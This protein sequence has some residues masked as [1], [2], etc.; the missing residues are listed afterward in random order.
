MRACAFWAALTGPWVWTVMMG[1]LLVDASATLAV[2]FGQNLAICP[3]WLQRKQSPLWTLCRFSSSVNVARA[4]VRPMSMAFGLRL[5]SAFLHWN[6]VA[7]ARR[8]PPLTLSFRKMYSCWWCLA[9]RVQSF[10]VTGWSNFT[11]FATIL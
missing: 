5:L 3:F 4:L 9:A 10:Q 1:A 11:Q 8:S 2:W 7:P 6:L